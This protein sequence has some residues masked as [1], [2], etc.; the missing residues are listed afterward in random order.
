MTI[1]RV[2]WVLPFQVVLASTLLAGLAAGPAGCAV[3][4][5]PGAESDAVAII[6]GRLF[7]GTGAAAIDDGAVVFEGNRITAVGPAAEVEVPPGAH[8]IDAGGGLIMPGVI[9]NHMHA[10]WPNGAMLTS[11]EDT[12]TPW[13]Q[14]GVTTLVDTGTIRHTVRAHRALANSV[15]HPP[16]FFMAGPLITVPG[17][18]P[19]T[20]REND[21]DMYA[22]TIEGPDEAYEVTAKLIDE[23]EVDLIKVAVET[24]F[25]TDY[26]STEG[27][28]TLSMDELR[29]IVRAAHERGR[30]VRAHVTNPLELL[31]AAQAGVDIAAHTPIHEIPDEVLDE[32]A[33]Y[34]MI[35]ISTA[36]IWGWPQG[37]RGR[38]V[39]PNLYR[40]HQRGGVVALGTDVPY[41][42]GSIMPVGEMR[43][44]IDAG[45]TPAEVL[46]AA[47][48]NSAMAL[49]MEEELGTL[50]VGKL[51][52]I[53]VVAGDP[54]TDIEAM[55]NVRVVVRDGEIIP[56]PGA[57]V[58]R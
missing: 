33:T 39:G 48:R 12:L 40:Y 49:G 14:A 17:G 53:I 36:N 57:P 55:T 5:V 10:F 13:L 44:F 1:M 38:P 21:I 11:D 46:V 45:F 6:N 32:V 3:T 2:R 58:E 26:D 19:T 7:D 31:A 42:T 27:W 22:W 47:T 43:L 29:A 24:G 23:E 9:D 25:D 37:E 56:M 50:E 4:S 34:D 52:D 15:A 28:P 16:R 8:V 18:Y 35:F 20:R 51:A 54:L 30:M 41:Q